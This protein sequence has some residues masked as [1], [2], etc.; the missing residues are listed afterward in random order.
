MLRDAARDTC[1]IVGGAGKAPEAIASLR[2]VEFG[3]GAFPL[4]DR[5]LA[6]RDLGAHRGRCRSGHRRALLQRWE[7]RSL[8]G[9][10]LLRRDTVVGILLAG[11]QGVSARF[12][13]RG[14]ELFRGIA[15]HVAIAL[16]NVRL[17]DRSAPRQQ[18]QVRVPLHHVARAAHAAQRDHRLRRP[19]ARRGLRA[20]GRRPA[21]RPRP[22]AHQRALAARADQRDARGQ[23]HRGR[24]HGVQLRE[25]DLRQLLTELQHE[26]DPLPRSPA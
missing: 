13:E 6:E 2:G 24:P 26:T 22:A 14:R 3:P 1:A 19:A 4:V 7:T 20:D 16:N 18:S 11:T 21:G 25:V 5:I 8:L 15:Q 10:A 12:T 17:V 23:P 9:A